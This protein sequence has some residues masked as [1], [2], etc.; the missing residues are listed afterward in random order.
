MEISVQDQVLR[1]SV[2]DPVTRAERK[3]T[4]LHQ[5]QSPARLAN[6]AEFIQRNSALRG[7]A[8]FVDVNMAMQS[9]DSALDRTAVTASQQQAAMPDFFKAV[10]ETKTI[11]LP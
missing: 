7:L 9:E 11:L 2:Q 4:R 10:P 1:R 8:R 3:K 6:V 5:I